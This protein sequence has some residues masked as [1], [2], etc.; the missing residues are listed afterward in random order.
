QV[1]RRETNMHQLREIQE[2]LRGLCP[3]SR[4]Q[5]PHRHIWVFQ[6][7]P[8]PGP[9]DRA[10]AYEGADIQRLWLPTPSPTGGSRCSASN[11]GS[12]TCRSGDDGISLIPVSG[13]FAHSK[14]AD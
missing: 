12:A 13:P 3:A 6:Y 9:A 11:A 8:R 7:W 2:T 5:K 10:T 1:W 14:P 4:V